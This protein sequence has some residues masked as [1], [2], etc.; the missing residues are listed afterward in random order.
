MHSS[1]RY[2]TCAATALLAGASA[3][4]VW[5]EP[6]AAGASPVLPKDLMEGSLVRINLDN[7][8]ACGFV[9]K[10]DGATY[11]LT[12]T[13][14]ISGHSRFTISTLAGAELRPTGI[15]LST[16]RDIARIRVGSG[17]GLDIAANVADGDSVVLVD[18]AKP[19]TTFSARGGTVENTNDERF[20]ITA[21]FGK[22]HGGS[23]VVNTATK[24]CGIAANID[25]FKAE[26]NSWVSTERHVNYRIAGTSWFAPNWRQYDKQFGRP[27]RDADEFRQIIYGLANQ[28]MGDLKSP[29]E[30]DADVDLDVQR[31]IKQ[32]NG[33]VTNLG[34]K[35]K[36]NKG[37]GDPLAPIRKDFSDSC[38][39]LVDICTSKAKT[40]AFFG[41]QANA[42]PFTV[43]QFKMRARELVQFA[44]F[45]RAFEKKNEYYR[46]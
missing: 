45:V 40:L 26:G 21:T 19:G 35:R 4:R 34:K 8:S 27:L 12:N 37:G 3:P 28:W 32:H 36:R 20:D 15:E 33:M 43:N 39:A 16:T 5:A 9:A 44:K 31:W 1:R 6:G 25:Y 42:S 11:V 41:E 29:I 2:F 7:S 10:M 18:F 30:T 38:N 46:W 22:E 23:P 17:S 14:L 24:V 13:R